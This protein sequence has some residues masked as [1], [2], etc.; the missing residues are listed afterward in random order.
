MW[1]FGVKFE[2]LSSGARVLHLTIN[3]VISGGC[4]EEDRRDMSENRELKYAR[5]ETW[6]AT[7]SELFSLST[8]LHQ[9]AFA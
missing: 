2:Y 8:C 7:G 9:S 1:L 6:T 4:Q 3:L 5:F